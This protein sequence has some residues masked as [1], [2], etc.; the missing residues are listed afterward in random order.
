MK[1]SDCMTQPVITI[2]RAAPVAA[3]INLMR[4]MEVHALVSE[5][6]HCRD[7]Y[8]I[9]TASDIAAKIVATGRSPRPLKTHSRYQI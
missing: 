5:P 9:L 4:V 3:T 1:I 6:I 2:S 8:G 7:A